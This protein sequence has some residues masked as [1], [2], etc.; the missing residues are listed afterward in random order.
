MTKLGTQFAGQSPMIVDDER[1]FGCPCDGQD[2]LCRLADIFLRPILGAQLKDVGT[3][4]AELLQQYLS[5]PA[6]ATHTGQ[7]QQSQ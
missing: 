1:N 3:A 5:A 2:G 4:V 7:P 6:P